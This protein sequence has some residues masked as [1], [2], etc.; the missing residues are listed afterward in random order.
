[1]VAA[2]ATTKHVVIDPTTRK[3]KDLPEIL[4]NWLVDWG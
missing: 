1:V 3:R 4:T 2:T